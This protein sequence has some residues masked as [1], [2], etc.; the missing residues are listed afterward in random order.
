[1]NRPL[2]KFFRRDAS[3]LLLTVFFAAALPVDATAPQTKQET[4]P[5]AAREIGRRL[6]GKGVPNFGEVTP[7]LYRGGLLKK[8]GLKALKQIGINVV[9]D[10]RRDDKREKKLV[11]DLGME[12]VAIPW[13]CPWPK[14]EV[15]ARFL[16]VVHDN[17]G[18]KIFVHC[19]LGDDR[20][21]MMVAAY[22]MAEEHW[23]AEEAMNEMRSFGFTHSHHYICPSLAKYEETF[24]EHLKNDPAFAEERARHQQ[25]AK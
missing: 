7:T 5:P 19:R 11:E 9:I 8:Q 2:M 1:M 15:F 21:G 23:T 6:N 13:H 3:I 4:Q 25:A 14:D 10:N 24:P 17:R 22:R 16:K 20:T 18:K 12:Y